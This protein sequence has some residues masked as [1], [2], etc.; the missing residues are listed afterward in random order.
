MFIGITLGDVVNAL[1]YTATFVYYE[2]I[3]NYILNASM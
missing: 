2:Y 3:L 1:V